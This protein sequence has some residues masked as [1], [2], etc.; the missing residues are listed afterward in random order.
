MVIFLYLPIHY[1]WSSEYI[2]APH[3]VYSSGMQLKIASSDHKNH[4]WSAGTV[5]YFHSISFESL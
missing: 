5:N 2:F 1:W 4:F 3:Y